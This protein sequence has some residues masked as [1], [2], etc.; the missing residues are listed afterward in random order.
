MVFQIQGLVVTA[1]T[2]VLISNCTFQGNSVT[3]NN[4]QGFGY[5]GALAGS[6]GYGD[7]LNEGSDTT[8][9]SVSVVDSIFISNSV[10]G[11]AGLYVGGAVTLA[12]GATLGY[13]HYGQNTVNTSVVFQNVVMAGNSVIGDTQCMNSCSL[14]LLFI[15]CAW[16]TRNA[17][18][19]HWQWLAQAEG[20]SASSS[21]VN[22]Q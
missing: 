21:V 20:R 15:A 17:V 5:G 6:I 19:F 10:S 18:C 22:S 8:N 3:G 1:N 9:T 11:A 2:T 4:I 7:S 16:L 12:I 14:L 13:T